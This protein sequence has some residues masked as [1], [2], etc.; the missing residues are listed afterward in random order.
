[1]ALL[2]ALDLVLIC[3]VLAVSIRTFLLSGVN[4][5]T[6]FYSAKYNSFF[7][8]ELK[9][10]YI[11]GIGWPEDAVEV[12]NAIYI[13]YSE[14]PPKGK[15]RVAGKNGMPEWEDI[16]PLTHEEVVAQ[17]GVEKQ[18]L[19]SAAND[20]INSNQWPGKAAMGRLKDTDKA[21]YNA[22][23]DYLDNIE[24]VEISAAPDITWPNPPEV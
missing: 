22:W 23:L 3:P 24:A 1:M 12:T 11:N 10:D 18:N 16:P 21:K 4:V 14:E 9:D 7:P 8:L 19:I 17:A 15:I 2:T 20:Y 5:N 6:Y 13:E